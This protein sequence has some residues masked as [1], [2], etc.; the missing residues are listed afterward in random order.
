MDR[1]NQLGRRWMHVQIGRSWDSAWIQ[2][3]VTVARYQRE[4][5][6]LRQVAAFEVAVS[7]H[8][9]GWCTNLPNLGDTHPSSIAAEEPARDKV[10]AEVPPSCVHGCNSHRIGSHGSDCRTRRRPFSTSPPSLDASANQQLKGY[11]QQ[12]VGLK[13][14]IN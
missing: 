12:N 13:L 3:A 10:V 9:Q 5:L 8:Q 7:L 11:N 2:L 14:E 6:H 4:L 1:W